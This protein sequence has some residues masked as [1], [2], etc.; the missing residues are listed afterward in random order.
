MECSKITEDDLKFF[1]AKL[2][3]FADKPKQDSF[4]AKYMSVEKTCRKTVKGRPVQQARTTETKFFFMRATKAVVRVC[5]SFFLKTLGIGKKRQSNIAKHLYSVGPIR[6][7]KRGGDRKREKYAARKASV[8]TFL[9][10]L[11][12]RESHY[13]RFKSRKIYLSPELKRCKQIWRL[14]NQKYR[15]SPELR[16]KYEYFRR[17]FTTQFHIGFGSPKSDAC[18]YCERLQNA[19][20]REPDQQKKQALRAEYR[21]HKLRSNAFYDLLKEKRADLQILTFDHQQNQVGLLKILYYL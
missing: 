11:K 9:K 19:I 17:I 18:S 12:G 7:E 13:G 20:R 2:Y 16:V 1:N 14:Y 6:P 4:L 8:C 21:I 3:E 15:D 10:S 5:Q